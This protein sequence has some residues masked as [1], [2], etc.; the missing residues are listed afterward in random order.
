MEQCI[1]SGLRRAARRR[2]TWSLAGATL[3]TLWS[4][5]SSRGSAAGP[6][7]RA[8]EAKVTTLNRHPGYFSEPSVAINP[9]NAQ[10]VVVAFQVGAQIAYSEDAGESWR[11]AAGTKPKGYRVSGDVS[12]A[13]DNRGDAIL[14]YIAFDKLG[15]YN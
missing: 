4:A 12:V 2:K 3:L 10:Q 7:A 14:C 13:Y 8:P 6:L 1:D 5:F 11:L 15:T 9:L